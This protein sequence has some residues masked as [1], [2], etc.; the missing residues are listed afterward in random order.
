MKKKIVFFI[1][2]ISIFVPSIYV[3]ADAIGTRYE[4]YA[5][6]TQYGQTHGWWVNNTGGNP[7]IYMGNYPGTAA[8]SF[9]F[10][11]KTTDNWF[12]TIVYNWEN[13]DEPGGNKTSDFSGT[14]DSSV[15]FDYS[16]SLEYVDRYRKSNGLTQFPIITDREVAMYYVA[17]GVINDSSKVVLGDGQTLDNDGNI[18]PTPTFENIGYPL[19]FRY[20][21]PGMYGQSL[22]NALLIGNNIHDFQATWKNK[23]NAMG[24]NVQIQ[25]RGTYQA[26]KNWMSE[27][28]TVISDWCPIDE[29]SASAQQW[30][31]DEV[32]VDFGLQS[33]IYFN[34]KE[35][36]GYSP[37]LSNLKQISGSMRIR[38]VVYQGKN[39][40]AYG[41][42]VSAT[43]N[44]NGNNVVVENE[45]GQPIETPEYGDGTDYTGEDLSQDYWDN[46]ANSKGIITSILTGISSIV[47]GIGKIPML[48]ASIMPFFPPE[49]WTLITIGIGCMVALGIFKII[50]G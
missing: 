23:E 7:C 3:K 26:K 11:A 19:E 44:A 42:W 17:A 1:M 49:I 34:I 27:K 2:L 48:V 12:E 39:V 47:N 37:S 22:K 16:G 21:L 31:K 4:W 32:F 5:P 43:I 24:Y 9:V 18:I 15:A 6:R 33:P 14:P 28:K 10:T 36:L 46:L 40:K 35:K 38:Y 30:T 20:F 8:Y 50:R 45:E 29:V 25:Y 13:V 41:N